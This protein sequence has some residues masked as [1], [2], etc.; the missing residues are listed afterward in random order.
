M[1]EIPSVVEDAVK[2]VKRVQEM[3]RPYQSVASTEEILNAIMKI[4]AHLSA[5]ETQ[6]EMNVR[7]TKEFLDVLGRQLGNVQ[8]AK[9]PLVRVNV[10]TNVL[11]IMVLEPAAPHVPIFVSS[12]Q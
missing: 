6:Q 8:S 1:K 12:L 7:D 3:K 2:S 4:H 10:P 11:R 5:E 9:Q